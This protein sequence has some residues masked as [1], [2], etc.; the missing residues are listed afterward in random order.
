MI[1]ET[2]ISYVRDGDN[3]FFKIDIRGQLL[4]KTS[5]EAP[6]LQEAK[7]GQTIKVLS[8]NGQCKIQWSDRTL[9]HLHERQTSG[10]S[11]G[12]SGR[13][14]S[15]ETILK[16]HPTQGSGSCSLDL[17]QYMKRRTSFITVLIL[18]EW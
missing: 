16:K 15:N 18:G 13:K 11:P 10:V 6:H 7:T 3:D 2:A 12:N 9:S 8:R 5:L 1:T 17:H 4:T 14:D